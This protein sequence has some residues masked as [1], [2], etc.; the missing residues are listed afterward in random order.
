MWF[1]GPLRLNHGHGLQYRLLRGRPLRMQNVDPPSDSASYTIGVL[2]S[3][4]GG[5]TIRIFPGVWEILIH[6]A[7][8]PKPTL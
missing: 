5:S 7:K 3:Q 4:N 6:F 8:S 1:V 2:E